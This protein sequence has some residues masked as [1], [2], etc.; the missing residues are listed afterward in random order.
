MRQDPLVSRS[1][2]APRHVLRAPCQVVRLRDFRLVADRTFD[3]STE[4][5]LVTPADAVMTGEE[6]LVSLRLPTTDE[7][8]DATATVAR[9]VHGRRPGE[10]TRGL[11]LLFDDLDARMRGLLERSLRRVPLCPPKGRPGRRWASGS[12]GLARLSAP[13]AWS[14]A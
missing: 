1:K 2:R 8:L 10:W 12:A 5:L 6:V 11:G 14:D 9:V 4:G 7:W 13:L 3:L